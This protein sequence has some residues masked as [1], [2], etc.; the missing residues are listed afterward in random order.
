MRLKGT[1]VKLRSRRI[2]R[3]KQDV[4]KYIHK[5]TMKKEAEYKK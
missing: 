3:K 2:E 1:V 4:R 5:L